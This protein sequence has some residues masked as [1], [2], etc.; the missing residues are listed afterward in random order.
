MVTKIYLVRHAEAAGNAEEFFQG[1][2]DT[3]LTEKGERQ[4]DFLAERFRDIPLDALYFSP[5]QRTK[6]TAEAVNRYHGLQMIPEYDLREINGGQWEGRTWR[7]LP[8]AFPEAYRQWTTHM[9]A[10]QAPQGD[11]MCDVWNR[12]LNVMERIARENRGKTIA[13][14][15]HGCALRNFLCSVEFDNPEMLGEVGWA[16][17]TAVSLV[18]YD[19]DIEADDGDEAEYWRLIFKNNSDH[20]PPELSTLRTSHW[21]RY[22]TNEESRKA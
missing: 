11:A 17:N 19:P 1:N 14:V 2:I 15:S 18:E 20:L 13:V 9:A 3:E 16:D 4:L 21:N 7:E 8:E 5:Y 12:M 22:E 6:L 10:F